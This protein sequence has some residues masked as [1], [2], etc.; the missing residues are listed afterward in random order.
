MY[1]KIDMEVDFWFLDQDMDV[2]S[3]RLFTLLKAYEK[4]QKADGEPV[5]AKAEI[6]AYQLHWS[7]VKKVSRVSRTLEEKGF[8]KKVKEG[9]RVGY[10]LLDKPPK[11]VGQFN[12]EIGVDDRHP[13]GGDDRH[14]LSYI[15]KSKSLKED[16]PSKK[17]K[18]SELLKTVHV[19]IEL[20]NLEGFTEALDDWLEYK[21]VEGPASKSYKGKVGLKAFLNSALTEY[22]KGTD[23]VQAINHAIGSGWQGVHYRDFQNRKRGSAWVRSKDETGFLDTVLDRRSNLKVLEGGK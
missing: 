5:F 10:I 12:S 13:I 22:R 21:Q 19:P 6:L 15:Y 11:L 9:R 7:D 23:I 4:A 1:L 3:L 16:M 18:P 8:L 20:Q 14:L 2:L 17:M